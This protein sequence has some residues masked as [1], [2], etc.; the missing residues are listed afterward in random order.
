MWF[1]LPYM[2][3]SPELLS[4]SNDKIN[5]LSKTLVLENTKSYSIFWRYIYMWK[6][7]ISINLSY[8]KHNLIFSW[9]FHASNIWLLLFFCF[10]FQEIPWKIS[11][12][13]VFPCWWIC[14][15]CALAANTLT[16][17]I[18]YRWA[19]ELVPG[20]LVVTTFPLQLSR[21]ARGSNHSNL[22]AAILQE[23]PPIVT[24]IYWWKQWNKNLCLKCDLN[25]PQ[26]LWDC[27]TP[28]A[29]IS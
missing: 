22:Q 26:P 16:K 15:P 12:H 23:A 29:V 5:I 11:D 3:F 7:I 9:L 19:W 14:T 24:L 28:T 10:N 1:S 17:F 13:A 2:Y 8:S 4:L 6:S 18:N 25:H 27:L 20:K 21:K